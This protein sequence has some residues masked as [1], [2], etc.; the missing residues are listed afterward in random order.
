MEEIFTKGILGKKQ[1]VPFRW[2]LAGILT[3]KQ[4]GNGT[5]YNK[6]L[7]GAVWMN[8]VYKDQF[9]GTPLNITYLYFLMLMELVIEPDFL[10]NLEYQI[11]RGRFWDYEGQYFH[12][13]RLVQNIRKMLI[14]FKYKG[15]IILKLDKMQLGLFTL[16]M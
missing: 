10:I 8:S 13:L 11:L 3:F 1:R 5:S 4:V 12:F 14:I 7:I 15:N 16:S 9:S 2:Y 6:K